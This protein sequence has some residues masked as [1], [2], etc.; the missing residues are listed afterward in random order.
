M[1]GMDEMNDDDAPRLEDMPN[2]DDPD[3]LMFEGMP[4]TGHGFKITGVTGGF[5]PRQQ[6]SLAGLPSGTHVR[7][8]WEG[9]VEDITFK[10]VKGED[11]M[12]RVHHIRVGDEDVVTLTHITSD[13]DAE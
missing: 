7:G 3:V 5:D 4:V 2:I 10:K 9:K 1:A 6:F 11:A 8:E 13:L 12:L